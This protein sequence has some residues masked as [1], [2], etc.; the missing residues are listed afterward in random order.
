MARALSLMTIA[1][2]SDAEV[3][4]LF[5]DIR[6]AINDGKPF[7]PRCG[8]VDRIGE[9]RPNPSRRVRVGLYKCYDCSRQFSVTSGTIFSHHKKSLREYLFAIAIFG[10][11]S[12]GISSVQLARNLGCQYKTA[13]VLSH[14]LREAI[15]YAFSGLTLSGVVEID[16]CTIGGHRMMESSVRDGFKQRIY[17]KK[18]KDRRVVTVMRERRG[19]T[20]VY[21]GRKESDAIG[22]VTARITDGSVIQ[23]DQSKAWDQLK[24]LFEMVRGNHKLSFSANGACTNM[25]ESFFSLLRKMH[26]GTHHKISGE[27]LQAYATELAWRQ[28]F[29]HLADDERVKMLLSIALLCP[30]SQRWSGYMSISKKA[31]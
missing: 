8:G 29:R 19:R 7:C 9:L 11:A 12:K 2:M 24:R 22:E 5:A 28:D 27:L 14:K 30:P 6:W 21:V 16:G 18:F 23:A 1:R 25:A 13:F 15:S 20:V 4:C 10:A 26:G 31:A 17:K 3:Q